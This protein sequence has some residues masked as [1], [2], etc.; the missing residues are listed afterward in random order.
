M[1]STANVRRTRI[2]KE[3]PKGKHLESENE[4]LLH[5]S[6]GE[7]VLWSATCHACRKPTGSEVARLL[8]YAILQII[9]QEFVHELEVSLP[10]IHPIARVSSQCNKTGRRGMS[11]PGALVVKEPIR[12]LFVFFRN[13]LRLLVPLKPRLILLVEP[14]TLILQSAG[15]EPLLVGILPVVED[16]E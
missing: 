1:K 6:R 15:R 3:T 11:L 5:S 8:W 9:L 16:V 4:A 10:A 13:L 7:S 12:P 2:R 14:P